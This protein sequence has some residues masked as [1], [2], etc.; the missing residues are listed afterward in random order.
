[1]SEDGKLDTIISI[2]SFIT[3][4]CFIIALIIMVCKCSLVGSVFLG[5]GCI[6]GICTIIALTI[7]IVRMEVL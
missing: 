2:V 6:F 1:M 5:L 4:C 7:V 3:N